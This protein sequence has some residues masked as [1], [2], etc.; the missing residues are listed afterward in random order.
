MIQYTLK[1]AQGHAFESWFQSAD[2]YDRLA[3]SGMV[4]CAVCGGVDVE[5]AIMAP[6]VQSARKRSDVPA[7]KTPERPLSQPAHPAEQALAELRRKIEKNADY[8]GS[9]FAEE[10]RAIHDGD[11]P[12]RA[13]YGEARL[14][15]ARKLVDDGVSVTPLPFTPARKAN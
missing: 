12:E 14:D 4:Q 1:C 8:V 11:A 13:I 6:R 3:R 15:E 10:A 5:K 9:D 7:E 2:A